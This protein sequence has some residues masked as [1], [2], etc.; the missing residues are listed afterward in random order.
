LI[1]FIVDLLLSICNSAV[2]DAILVVVDRYTKIARYVLYNKICIAEK[3]VLMFYNKI[4]CH[5]S[6][7]NSIV[8]DYSSVFT[9]AY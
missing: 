4:I 1:D 6:I 9:S 8:P 7:L 2:Y 3:L 5:Y